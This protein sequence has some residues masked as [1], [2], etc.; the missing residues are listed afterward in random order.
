MKYLKGWIWT[1]PHVSCAGVAAGIF[2]LNPA[3]IENFVSRERL[4]D[5]VFLDDPDHLG[6]LFRRQANYAFSV[7]CGL[8]VFHL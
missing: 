6:N 3:P 5:L 8:W 2:Y 1:H 4:L 7:R